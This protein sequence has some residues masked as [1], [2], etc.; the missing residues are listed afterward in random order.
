MECNINLLPLLQIT[1]ENE[2]KKPHTQFL[3]ALNDLVRFQYE[4]QRSFFFS[5]E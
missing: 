5:P 1:Q 2:F 3:Q 4:K